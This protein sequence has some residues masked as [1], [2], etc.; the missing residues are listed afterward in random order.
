MDRITAHTISASSTSGD[1]SHWV[2]LNF[3]T[4]DE[5]QAIMPACKSRLHMNWNTQA[6]NKM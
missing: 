4:R 1:L 6:N 3:I 2:N 5:G